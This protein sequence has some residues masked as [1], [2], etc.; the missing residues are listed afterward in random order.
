MMAR[1]QLIGLFC[2]LIVPLFVSSLLYAGEPPREADLAQRVDALLAKSVPTAQPQL[3][4]DVTFLR[5]LSIDLTGKLP[6]PEEVRRFAA[7][8]DPAKRTKAIE[9]LLTSDAYAV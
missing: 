1:R 5:R 6:D 3:A 8:T 2:A 4:D 7:D 9:R